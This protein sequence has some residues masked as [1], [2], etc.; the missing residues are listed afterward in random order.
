MNEKTIENGN[1]DSFPVGIKIAL[2]IISYLVL[3]GVFQF[4]GM[5]VA[6]VSETDINA[7]NDMT[8]NQHII[9]QLFNVVALIIVICFFQKFLD[10][11]S[12]KSLGFSFKN[13]NRDIIVGFILA[14]STIGGGTLILKFFGYLKF[15][16][17]QVDIQTLFLNF[18]LFTIVAFS[19]EIFMRGYIL[20][21]LLTSMNKYLALLISAVIFALFHLF[22][23]NLSLIGIIDLFLAGIL[24]GSTYIFTKN[25]WFPISFHLFWNFFQGPIFGYSVSGTEQ[26]S[27]FVLE[28]IGN[29]IITV[30][31]F[32]FEGSI[33]CTI[34]T[35]LSILLI[36]LYYT[37]FSTQVH[38][39]IRNNKS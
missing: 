25:L 10:N 23:P 26:K 38:I 30:G 24:L 9:V 14:L 2:A 13:K 34:F 1:E 21:N 32:G 4:I 12:I 28:I 39:S 17:I 33:L 37:Q 22:N 35:I 29:K 5:V 11:K 18:I 20:N 6:G 8:I 3:G 27:L 15:S 36:M 31:E 16:N 7:L 19:E